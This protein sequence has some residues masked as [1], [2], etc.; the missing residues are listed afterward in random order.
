MFR[1]TAIVSVSAQRFC[2]RPQR[3][4]AA[5]AAAAPAA[6]ASSV[7]AASF[8]AASVAAADGSVRAAPVVEPL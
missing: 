5:A 4:A 6:A 1:L 8:A 2:Q 3:T 7:A